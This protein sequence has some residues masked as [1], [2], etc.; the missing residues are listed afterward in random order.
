MATATSRYA[1]NSEGQMALLAPCRRDD[2]IAR[3][4]KQSLGLASIWCAAIGAGPPL[5][6]GA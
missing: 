4:G 2:A 6:T 5:R 3:A 1:E